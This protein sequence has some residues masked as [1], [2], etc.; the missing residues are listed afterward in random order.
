M[1]TLSQKKLVESIELIER[2]WLET[3]R[4][5]VKLRNGDDGEMTYR[6]ADVIGKGSFGVV[7]RIVS[8]D[9]RYALKR[10]YQDRRYYN[11]ELSMLLEVDHSNI[12]N[13]VSYFHSDRSAS[14]MYLNIITEFVGINLEEYIGQDRRNSVVEIKSIY[15]QVLSGL[16]YL[17]ERRICHRDIKPSNILIDPNGHVKI[18]DLGSAKVIE[19]GGQNVTYICSRFYR[20][21]ENLL[22]Y[23]EYNTKIDIWSAGCVITEFRLPEPIFKG[24]SGGCTLNRILEIVR[25][26]EDD[27]VAVGCD[28]IIPRQAIGIRKYLEGHFEDPGILDV[29][30]RSLTFSP[31]KRATASELLSGRFFE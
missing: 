12:I 8:G 17:H 28:G 1:P 11:R 21:P 13:L 27:L 5:S 26:T 4:V 22:D 2:G 23:K 9:R 15:R 18:C 6:Y 30:E 29:L 31:H 16:A 10:V 25:A 24:D 20:A 14:G 19:E 3:H 7:V